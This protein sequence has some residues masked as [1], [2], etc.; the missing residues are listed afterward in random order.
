MRSRV[1]SLRGRSRRRL[2]GER[3]GTAVIVA[4]LLSG[5]VFMGMLAVSVD[6][7]NLMYERRQVQNGADSTSLALAAECATDEANCDPAVVEDL[8]DPNAGDSAM[9]YDTTRPSTSGGACVRG[10][11]AQVGTT[12]PQCPSAAGGGD[13]T[14]LGECPPLQP[15]L[16]GAGSGIPYVETY[17][18]TETAAGGDEL[19]LP[20]S[21][22]LAG[23]PAGD[24]GTSAC[25]RAAW[26]AP[27]GYGGAFPLTISGCEWS[28]AT[29]DGTDFVPN[30][31]GPNGY[32]T[33]GNPWPDVSKEVVLEIQN[34]KSDETC[35]DFNGHDFPGGFGWLETVDGCQA[36]VSEFNWVK[37]NP[38]NGPDTSACTVDVL[39]KVIEIPVYD[40]FARDSEPTGPPS[41]CPATAAPSGGNKT[42]YHLVGWAKFYVS[43]LKHTGSQSASSTMPG[44]S[45][46]CPGP[47]GSG[48]CV[49]GW[50]LSGPLS[51]KSSVVIGPP[52]GSNDFGVYIVQPAG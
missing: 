1:R 36:K 27:L 4:I 6:L 5:G 26:G 19:F 49:M 50:F 24:A 30:G 13:I 42:W 17:A 38:G 31:P 44:S 25:A 8:L 35:T 10:T 34:V 29:A 37:V 23:G 11:A 21:R 7:G 40:C 39:N 28:N 22:V 14:D 3:G 20:F 2:Q 16:L 33:T 41:T 52:D 51:P 46:T 45:N 9:Q 43:G 15:W 18:A 12:L 32:G 47:G 48:R